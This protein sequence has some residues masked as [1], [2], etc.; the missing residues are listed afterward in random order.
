MADQPS[1]Q[2]GTTPLLAFDPL[3]NVGAEQAPARQTPLQWIGDTAIE[4]GRATVGTIGD[5][6]AGSGSKE[7]TDWASDLAYRMG[8]QQ[9]ER[10]QYVRRHPEES[11]GGIVDEIAQTAIGLVPM[12]PL[13]VGAEAAGAAAAP[14][15][16]GTS[17]VAAPAA[18]FAGLSYGAMRRE[19][20]EAIRDTPE[21]DLWKSDRYRELRGVDGSNM[22]D[23]QARDILWDESDQLIPG[24]IAAGAGA[25][26]GGVGHAVVSKLIGRASSGQVARGISEQLTEKLGA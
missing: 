14:F 15:T 21:K 9:S 25:V 13:A 26:G 5:I 11:K 1:D 23:K 2:P 4:L 6:A 17:L 8:R 3:M 20:R 18:T 10:A 7:M 22:T 24:L 16:A 19:V 12:I